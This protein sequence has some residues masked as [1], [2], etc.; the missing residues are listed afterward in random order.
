MKRIID[1]YLLQWKCSRVRKPLL[2]RG[3]RQIGKTYAARQL[4]KSYESYVEINLELQEDIRVLFQ[5]DLDPAKIIIKIFAITGQNIIPGKTLLFLDEI[6]VVPRAITALRYFYEIMPELHVI[7]A[8]SLLDFAIQQEGIP[9]GRVQELYMHPVSFFEYL[10]TQNKKIAELIMRHGA[11]APMSE[12]IHSIV[13]QDLLSRYLVIGGMPEA[14]V[15]WLTYKNVIELEQIHA[16]ILNTYRQ[17]FPKYAS[18]HEIKY[19]EKVFGYIP[20]QSGHKFKYSSIEGDYR[21]RELS[22]ALDLL[23][24]AGVVQKVFYSPGQGVPL[25]AHKDDNDF[26]VIFLDVGLAQSH[27]GINLTDW[28][29]QSDRQFVNKGALVEAFVG[30]EIAA[31]LT[32]HIKNDLFY[33]HKDSA[34]QQAEIDYL[35]QIANNIIPV[36]VKSGDGRGLK[37]L[38]YFIESHEQT[39][40]GLRFSTQD[41]SIYNNI[42]SYPLY[43][44]AKVMSNNNDSMK[45]A[46]ISLVADQKIIRY[47]AT[48]E[49]QPIDI[50]LLLKHH[51]IIKEE[52]VIIDYIDNNMHLPLQQLIE[53]LQTIFSLQNYAAIYTLHNVHKNLRI[54]QLMHQHIV[55]WQV[56]MAELLQ[57]FD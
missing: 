43:A 41:Y 49:T 48:F 36:E 30:Q 37:S 1:Y 51:A 22:P 11:A 31:Y 28:F 20:Q 10:A 9:V 6:Q 44:I 50:E 16:S 39:P 24:A 54:I 33:W 7:A 27:L 5:H 4:G 25:G 3:A 57:R 13:I 17:D 55:V 26:K 40:F 29:M 2:L 19:V 18:K 38:H 12:P 56:S 35:V 52:I 47:V 42:H 8:G 46:M 53:G 34:P 23:V 32:P 45:N 15:N 21:K 14:I